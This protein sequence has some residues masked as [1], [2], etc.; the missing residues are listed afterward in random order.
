MEARNKGKAPEKKEVP[1]KKDENSF[2]IEDG[3]EIPPIIRE[4]NE[5]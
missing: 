2:G 4:I 3:D 1:E 5:E